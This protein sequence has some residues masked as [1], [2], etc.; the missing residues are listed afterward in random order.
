MRG[1]DLRISYSAPG[2]ELIPT[3]LSP[4]LPLLPS[5]LFRA[6]RPFATVLGLDHFPDVVRKWHVCRAR[7]ELQCPAVALGDRSGCR[8]SPASG[9]RNGETLE[10]QAW[11]LV[12]ASPW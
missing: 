7:A 10:A 8:G 1:M 2:P 6:V 3:G 5:A 11:G 4:S 12:A 9:P